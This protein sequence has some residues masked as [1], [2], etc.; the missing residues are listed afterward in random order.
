MPADEKTEKATPKRRQDERKK[1][2]VFQSN[3]VAA[4]CSMLVLFHS[5]KALAP[6]M[7]RNFRD[8]MYMFMGMAADS[9][10]FHQEAGREMLVKAMLLFLESALPLLFIGVLT[11]VAVTFF[12]TRMAFSMDVL[13][14]KMER[15][16]P[17]KGFKRM[18]SIR[19]VVE[20][21]K[22]L[23]KI[24]ILGWVVY[25][26][27]KGRMEE[28][29]RLMEGTVEGALIFT[30][31]TVISLVDT[32]GVAFIFLASMDYLYQWWEYEKNLR[33]SKQ[34]IK[35]E[36][37]QTEG[38]PQIKGKIRE[39]QRQMASMRM[40]QNVP[41]ADVIVRNPTHYAV[42]LGY[43]ADR[44]RAPVVLAKGADH[45][46]LKIVEVGEANGVYILEDRPL[47]RGLY[48]SVEVDME[49][50]EEYYQTVAKILAFVYK[51]NDK[52][53]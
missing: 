32:V 35:E 51:L 18:F 19:S 28:L 36:Y 42:A 37:K 34:E 30:G 4:V 27:L 3:D 23:I 53:L 41:K 10:S 21:I 40:M 44:N 9:D 25:V 12:Q 49:I 20:L 47:A 6:H 48:A 52:K 7:Y 31:N 2:N 39:K 38:D 33:M 46:A 14:F 45:L 26:F 17:L 8:A 11:A 13:K 1:G 15:I 29:S 16:S 24:T 5:L 43:D 50:P 22:A